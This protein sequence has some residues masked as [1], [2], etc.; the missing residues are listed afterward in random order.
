MANVQIYNILA[1]QHFAMVDH[2]AQKIIEAS[3]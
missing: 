2:A 3:F 1:T